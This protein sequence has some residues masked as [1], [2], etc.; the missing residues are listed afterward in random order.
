ME[1]TKSLIHIRDSIICILEYIF[2]YDKYETVD[3]E[4]NS[5]YHGQKL[6]YSGLLNFYV[7]FEEIG[8][9]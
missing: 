7:S 9:L 3:N 6:W 1:H 8:N 5:C 2:T 4:R